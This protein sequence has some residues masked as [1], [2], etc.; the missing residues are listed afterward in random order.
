MNDATARLVELQAESHA[1]HQVIHCLFNFLFPYIRIMG[2][3]ELPT[4]DQI[5]LPISDQNWKYA[6]GFAVGVILTIVIIVILA[7][8]YG[9]EPSEATSA[10]PPVAPPPAIS[11][12][13]LDL[14][15]APAPVEAPAGNST[16]T[17]MAAPF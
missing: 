13:R 7:N 10:P 8:K 15:S 12:P 16:E 2:E 9:K 6:I 14:T 17:Y 5:E 1:M 3:I 4:S 11:T